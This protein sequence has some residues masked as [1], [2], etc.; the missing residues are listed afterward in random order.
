[1]RLSRPGE[2]KSLRDEWLDLLM[3]KEVEESHQIL[4][5]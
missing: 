4:S 3:A 2:R 1:M 5:K